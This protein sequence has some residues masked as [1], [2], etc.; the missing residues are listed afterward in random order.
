VWYCPQILVYYI[1]MKYKKIKYDTVREV[2]F[3]PEDIARLSDALQE[4]DVPCHFSHLMASRPDPV[5]LAQVKDVIETAVS[6]RKY[7][8]L[9][10]RSQGKTY[11]EISLVL[12]ISK[13]AVQHHYRRAVHQVRLALGLAPPSEHVY[14]VSEAPI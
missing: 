4:Q 10:L 5:R 11:S 13:S 8:V 2:S 3:A 1:L 12:E 9:L 6:G 7:E 14:D